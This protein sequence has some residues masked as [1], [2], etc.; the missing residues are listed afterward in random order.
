MIRYNKYTIYAVC[1]LGKWYGMVYNKDEKLVYET[2]GY[3]YRE[4][5]IN[6]AKMVVNILQVN[7]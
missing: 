6:T 4:S 5:A 2:E 1:T 7:N 3:T